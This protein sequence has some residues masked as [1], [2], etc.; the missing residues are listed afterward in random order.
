MNCA[1]IGAGTY[2]EV[3][4]AYLIEAGYNVTA[5]FDSNSSLWGQKVKGVLI[6]DDEKLLENKEFEDK[7]DA[8]FCPIGNN[9]VRQKVLNYVSYL[10]Y[11]TPNFIHSSVVIHDTVKL[12]KGVYILP[13]SIV[14]PYTEIRDYSM[15]SMGVNLAHHSIL[16]K[17]CFLSTGVNFG[18]SI[19]AK[20][21]AYV[22]IGATIMTGIKTLGKN[23][24]V[25]AGSVVIKDVEDNAVVAGVPA[26]VIKYKE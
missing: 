2:G 20:E 25:G 3:Y 15:I 18:A 7:I 6:Y 17:G 22:G 16:D 21:N 11:A 12:G 9:V 24:L 26:K 19:Y 13:G 10:G 14:M 4:M 5:F 8:L 1:I 23:C